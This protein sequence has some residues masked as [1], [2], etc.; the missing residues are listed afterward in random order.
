MDRHGTGSDVRPVHIT[1]C[2]LEDKPCPTLGCSDRH[3]C[4]GM[5]GASLAVALGICICIRQ[6]VARNSTQIIKALT[7]EVDL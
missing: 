6:D 3:V 5:M 4:D 2:P 1:S 7:H